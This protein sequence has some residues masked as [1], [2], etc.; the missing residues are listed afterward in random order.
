MTKKP[1][2]LGISF[3]EKKIRFRDFQF[4][5]GSYPKSEAQRG[6]NKM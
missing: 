5:L 3:F 2:D 4:G 6:Q 1:S